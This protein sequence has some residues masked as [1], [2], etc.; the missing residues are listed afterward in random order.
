MGEAII[1]LWFLGVAFFSHFTISE[2]FGEQTKRHV[3][4]VADGLELYL[5]TPTSCTSKSLQMFTESEF[6][7]WHIF[8]PVR[9]VSDRVAL[10]H[11]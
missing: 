5:S 8:N 4:I 10:N 9:L 7:S 3:E 1:V 2:G 11:F 6:P